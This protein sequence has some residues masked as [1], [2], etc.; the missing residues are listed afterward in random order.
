MVQS[1]VYEAKNDI[2]SLLIADKTVKVSQNIL[3]MIN[4]QF[5]KLNS[6]WQRMKAKSISKYLWTAGDAL[7]FSTI[8]RWLMDSLRMKGFLKRMERRLS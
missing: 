8:S 4:H 2:Y 5:R 7:D 1:S 3:K 6:W